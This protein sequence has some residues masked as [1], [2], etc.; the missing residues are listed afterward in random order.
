G[1]EK[2]LRRLVIGR[3]GR[4]T[5]NFA[6]RIAECRKLA[7]ENAASVDVDGVVEPERLGYRRMA[8]NHEGFA[9]IVLRP[10]VTHWQT[11][12]VCLT[13]RLTVER[14]LAYLAGAT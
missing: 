10:V 11:K 14:E 7:A 5:D 2:R 8:V 1:S 3:P 12:F 13:C 4:N 6:L 9:A